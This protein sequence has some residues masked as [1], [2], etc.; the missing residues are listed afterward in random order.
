[1]EF[2]AWPVARYMLTVRICCAVTG[3]AIGSD[4]ARAPLGI[5]M[6][7]SPPDHVTGARDVGAMAEVPAEPFC[8]TAMV[9][10]EM[11]RSVPPKALETTMR[12]V[13]ADWVRNMVW[14]RV[15]SWNTTPV[16]F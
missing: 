10:A 11:G 12:M 15:A 2:E 16:W 1:M 3:Y 6:L 13:G 14:R 9:A 4:T 8:G 7:A 5:V